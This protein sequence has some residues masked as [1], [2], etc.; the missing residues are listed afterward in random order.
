MV[1]KDFS[2]MFCFKIPPR[3]SRFFRGIFIHF[4]AISLTAWVVTYYFITRQSSLIIF[5]YGPGFLKIVKLKEII[6]KYSDK[7][8]IIVAISILFIIISFI[9]SINTYDSLTF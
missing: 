4:K 8:F 1:F 9:L 6:M 2:I 5:R 3:A 7:G